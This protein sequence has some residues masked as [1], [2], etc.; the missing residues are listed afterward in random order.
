MP[1]PGFVG[2]VGD[3]IGGLYRGAPMG[4]SMGASKSSIDTN[5]HTI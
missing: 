2:Y 5:R 3:F 1:P 4:G